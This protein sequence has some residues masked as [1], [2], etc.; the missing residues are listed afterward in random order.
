VLLGEVKDYKFVTIEEVKQIVE[1]AAQGKHKISPWFGIIFHQF[2]S[3]WWTKLVNKEE[4]VSEDRIHH[5]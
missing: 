2:L 3:A 5:L 1:E 4:F